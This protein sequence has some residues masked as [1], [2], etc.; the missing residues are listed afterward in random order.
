MKRITTVTGAVVLSTLLCTACGSADDATTS[1][2]ASSRLTIGIALPASSQAFWGGWTTAAQ[3]EADAQ[4]VDLVITDAGGDADTMNQDVQELIDQGVDGIAIAPVDPADNAEVVQAATSAGI[5]LITSNRT[6][7]V[8]YGG[9]GGAN[10]LVHT[11]FDDDQIGQL[12]GSLVVDSCADKNPCTVV[13]E[14]GTLGSS[15]QVLREQGLETALAAHPS[16]TIVEKMTNDFDPD[17]AVGVTRELL[18]RHPDVDVVLTQTDPEAVA[19]TGVV[20]AAGKS[21]VIDVIGI[22][23]SIDGIKSVQD[24]SLAGTVRVSAGEDGA[25]S[26]RTLVALVRGTDVE[27]AAG[28][29]PTVVVPAVEVTAQNADDNLGDW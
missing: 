16:I 3:A 7:D 19:A 12:Q 27:T 26:V 20:A 1:P 10:P 15:P 6:L 11:G 5:P 14:Q 23:G 18:E 13:L 8:A 9:A 2:A 4:G 25:T 21:D 24:G 22:G 17:V 28:D 29:R